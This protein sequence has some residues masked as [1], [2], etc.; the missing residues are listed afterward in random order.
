ML[1]REQRTISPSEYLSNTVS[2]T[3]TFTKSVFD[4]LSASLATP[5]VVAS[6]LKDEYGR[7]P[8][9]QALKESQEAVEIE[10]QAPG[11]GAGRWL[12]NEGANMLGMALNPVTCFGGEFGSL[13]AKEAISGADKVAPT[14]ASVFMRRPLV[15]HFSKPIGTWLGEKAAQKTLGEVVAPTFKVGSMFAGAGIPQ[16]AQANYDN[17]TRHINWGGVAASMGEMGAFGIAIDA[18]PFAWGLLKGKINRGRDM[19]HGETI[20]TH[21][22]DKAL[23]QGH[24][25]KDEHAWYQ[26]YMA[27]QKDPSNVDLEAKLKTDGSRLINQNGHTAN[28]VTDRAMFEILTPDDVTNLQGVVADQL[29]G[30]L[31]G[32]QKKALSDFIIHNRMD[33]IRQKP[34]WLDGVRGYV[35]HVDEKLKSREVM[36]AEADR[37]LDQ[38]M[39]KGVKENMPFSQ[40]SMLKHLRQAGFESSHVAHFPLSL[41]ENMQRHMKMMEKIDKL[42]RKVR[43]EKRRGLEPN[44]QTVK[45]IDDL[46]SKLPKILTP[47]EELTH[48]RDHLL[49]KGLPKNFERL[50]AY[51]RLVDLS[52]VWHN[53]KSV[54][55]RVHLEHEYNR[56]KAFRDLAGQTLKIADSDYGKI[57]N[58]D[59]VVDYLK[60]RI[61]GQLDKVEPIQN[62]QNVLQESQNVPADADTTLNNQAKEIGK[63]DAELN[64][65]GIFRRLLTDLKEFKKSDGV[66]KNLIA[67]VM[68]GLGG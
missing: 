54:L 7:T 1:T 30:D 47:K 4:N 52:H 60:T 50:P 61:E 58:P 24:I 2:K 19:P 27:F 13:A 62:V 67:C 64:E 9:G 68:G 56:Q 36:S 42:Q 6:M 44:K 12:A 5:A 8:E 20:D 40:K 41:P 66:F 65:K 11:V 39:L 34:E 3:P 63:I 53:A 38:H 48:L 21:A 22:L 51:H 28:T 49:G 45:R 25:T 10:N 14:A 15:E 23:E 46:Q 17:D 55:D 32:E 33:Y 16:A 18:I 31:P 35:D 37:I 57:S 29:S 59:N 26:D 43:L